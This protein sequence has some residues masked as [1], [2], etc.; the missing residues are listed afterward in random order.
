[1]TL[2]YPNFRQAFYLSIFFSLHAFF[3][4]AQ[5]ANNNCGTATLLTVNS[6]TTCSAI[7]NGT[8]V[9][10]TQ[11]QAGCVG[12]ANDDVWFRFVATGTNHAIT[13]TPN[14]LYDAVVQVFSGSCGAL[15]S[16]ACQDNTLGYETE[17]VSLSGLTVGSTYYVRVYSYYSSTSDNGTFSICVTTPSTGGYCYPSSSSSATR[18]VSFTATGGLANTINNT[19]G[20]SPGGYGNYTSMVVSQYPSGT[21]NFSADINGNYNSAGI[22][23][24]VDWNHDLDFTDAGETVY[25]SGGYVYGAT[26]SFAV[27]AGAATGNY[28][29]RIRADYW[30]QNPNSCGAIDEGEAEDYTLNVASNLCAALPGGLNVNG[31]GANSATIN[32]TAASPAPA[33]GYY[34]YY[35]TS[36]TPPGILSTGSG[37]V[38]A[39]VVTADLSGLAATTTYFVWVRSNCGGANGMSAWAGPVSFTTGMLT[40]GVSICAGESGNL[41]ASGSCMTSISV[42]NTINGSWNA[43]SDPIAAQIEIGMENSDACAFDS[44]TANYTT[45]N[46]TVSATGSYTFTMAPNAAYD[47]MGYIVVAPFTPGVCGSGTWVVGDDDSSNVSLE[48]SMTAVLSTGVTYTLVSTVF[49]F[50]N[51]TVTNSYQWNI[52]TSSGGTVMTGAPGITQWYTA[53]TGGTPIGTG[54][55]FNPVGVAGSG[56]SDTNTA[57]TTVYYAACSGNPTVRT[58]TEFSI[59]APTASISA[60][61]SLCEGNA[62][63]AI[64]LTGTPPWSIT[65]TNDI[66]DPPVTVSDIVASP[67][68]ISVSPSANA[69]YTIT[70]VGDAICAAGTPSGSAG[71][72]SVVWT[73]STSDWNSPGNWNT[74]S[75]PTSADCVVISA[76]ANHAVISGAVDAVAGQLVVE[77]GGRL[78]IIDART[79]TVTD[80]VTVATNGIFNIEN[81]A[82]LVQINDVPNSGTVNIKRNASMRLYDFTYWNSPITAASGFTLGEFAPASPADQIFSWTTTIGGNNGNWTAESQSSVMD[83]TRGYIIRAPGGTPQNFSIL[84]SYTFVGTP[85]NG[86]ISMPISYGTAAGDDDQWNLLGNPYPS[87]VS[88]ADFL[89]ANSSVLDETIYLWT[90]NTLPDTANPNPFYGEFYSNYSD[91]DYATVNSLGGVAACATCEIPNGY[92]SSGQAFFIKSKEVPGVAVFNNSMRTASN[93]TQFFRSNAAANLPAEKHRIWLNMTNT[94]DTFNQIMIGFVDGATSGYDSGYDGSRLSASDMTFYSVIPNERLAI[95]GLPLPFN[96]QIMIP[97]GFNAQSGQYEIGIEKLDP[98]FSDRNIYLED[99]QNAVIHNL[100][101]NPYTFNTTG[102][103]FDDRFVLRFT[104]NLLDNGSIGNNNLSVILKNG[105]FSLKSTHPI[106]DVNVFDAAGRLVETLLPSVAESEHSWPFKFAQGTYIAKIN[107]LDGSTETRRILNY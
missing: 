37:S 45:F 30:A 67:H 40:T 106:A 41:T 4:F 38:A 19:S 52:A 74:G 28:R 56:L 20:Y 22:R 49:G 76:A 7:T 107:M 88:V 46:F 70:S 73:G 8:T 15:S 89:S 94:T 54:S 13:V 59:G 92:I 100:K 29:M 72:S 11:S 61:G 58:P 82:S 62:A 102:G 90:H 26:G 80:G 68:I 9:N 10:A 60:T 65:Y 23:I 71:F 12:T 21:I 87:A 18:I 50:S 96:E 97:L 75:V 64:E 63:L 79:L 78:E 3:A 99:L 25:S 43:V 104:S 35:S 34:Y 16:I 24:W 42:G 31:I 55:T 85:N 69:N 81:G 105:I 36:S 83:P 103:R 27:P 32:W 66:G 98:F 84:H 14:S 86:N 93:N 48:P 47:G 101:E 1:M 5:P 44:E 6:G 57:G 2:L 51:I 17:N 39:G 95:Q 91:S 53:A 33:S 77:D